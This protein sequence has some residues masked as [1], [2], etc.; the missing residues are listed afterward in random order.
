[1]LDNLNLSV[2]KIEGLG[3][4]SRI[5]CFI[6]ADTVLLAKINPKS[7]TFESV[8]VNKSNV[9]IELIDMP[10]SQPLSSLSFSMNIIEKSGFHWLPLFLSSEDRLLAVPEEV[11]LPRILI[12]VHPSIMAPFVDYTESS[13]TCE[14]PIDDVSIED[15]QKVKTKNLELM[16]K[17]LQVESELMLYKK[18]AEKELENALHEYKASLGRVSSECEKYKGLVVKYTKLNNEL[19]KENEWLKKQAEAIKAKDKETEGRVERYLQLY[20][21]IKKRE[22]TILDVL[23]EKDKENKK[24]RDVRKTQK[25]ELC[26]QSCFGVDRVSQMFQDYNGVKEKLIE[27]ERIHARFKFFEEIDKKMK[28]TL[29]ILNLEGFAHFSNEVSYILGNKKVCVMVK[30]DTLHVKVAGTVKSL[31]SYISNNCASDIE[32]FLKKKKL[33]LDTKHKRSCTGSELD[34]FSTS[35]INKTYEIPSKILNPTNFSLK[36]LKPCIRK[37]FSPLSKVLSTTR[38]V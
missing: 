6:Y 7:P 23:E 26:R 37:A 36:S 30:N 10:S 16:M 3:D 28:N 19:A 35:I 25:L 15:S 4:L 14:E 12:D 5:Q 8:N 18:S 27:L 21:E 13:E 17:V 31:E 11:G 9:R 22:D 29:K 2:L 38:H 33:K 1:M 32:M 20:Q 34:K 24:L